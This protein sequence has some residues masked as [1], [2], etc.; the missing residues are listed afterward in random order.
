[1]LKNTR[2]KEGFRKRKYPSNRKSRE[3]VIYQHVDDPAGRV[4]IIFVCLIGEAL[5]GFGNAHLIDRKFKEAGLTKEALRA[6]VDLRLPDYPLYYEEKA[7]RPIN[8]NIYYQRF[9]KKEVY[10]NGPTGKGGT[11][12]QSR[13]HYTVSDKLRPVF[14]QVVEAFMSG[15]TLTLE[16]MMELGEPTS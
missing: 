12:G 4:W 9:H 6:T 13:E 8:D 1:M 14:P 15:K 7:K 3:P 11:P 16:K 5:L 10:T 2:V